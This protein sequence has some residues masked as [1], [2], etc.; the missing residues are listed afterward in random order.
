VEQE[1]VQH[2]L[3]AMPRASAIID[4]QVKHGF[5]GLFSR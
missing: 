1:H 4:P 2:R 5:G 3:A